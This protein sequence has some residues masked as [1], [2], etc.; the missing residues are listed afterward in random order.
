M[1]IEWQG[2]R[3]TTVRPRKKNE[4]VRRGRAARVEMDVK[5]LRKQA[6]D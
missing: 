2:I 1:K 6:D 5:G 3:R 4:S